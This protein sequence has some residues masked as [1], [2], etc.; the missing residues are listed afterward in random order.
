MQRR[1]WRRGPDGE[2]IR[3][4]ADPEPERE[5]PGEAP[6]SGRRP[7]RPARLG[8]ALRQGFRDTYDHLGTVLLISLLCSL[9]GGAA[10]AGAQAVGDAL[11]GTLRPALAALLA[12]AAAAAGLLLVGAPLAAGSFRYARNAAA[13]REPEVFDLAGGFHA[14]LGTSLG[15]GALQGMG[16]L[17]LA[18]NAAFY[19]S[20]RHPVGVVIGASFGY[21]LAFWLL[22]CLYQWPLLAEQELTPLRA[23]KK[24]A[25]LVLDNFPYTL[26]LAL[27]LGVISLGLWLSVIGGVLLWGGVTAMLLT[28]ATRELLRKYRVLPPDPEWDPGGEDE[29]P[30][31]EDNE[32]GYRGDA[33]Q[34]GEPPC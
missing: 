9:T 28:H 5:P 25:L 27:V 10:M 1:L 20:G 16:V 12:G 7:L 11:F 3:A 32:A 29:D 13:R 2:I 23:V 18:G 34:A 31:R 33:A 21:M 8:R 17:L 24:S 22:A 6:A 30:T 14:A 26:G 4:P 19:L 15:L